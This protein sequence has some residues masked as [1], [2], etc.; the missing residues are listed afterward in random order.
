MADYLIYGEDFEREGRPL[1]DKEQA[2]E[3]KIMDQREKRWKRAKV[4]LYAKPTE[5]ASPCG[6]LGPLGTP[7][8]ED[9]Y[10]VK[11]L[12]EMPLIEDE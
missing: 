8:D 3:I 11:V 10:F 4:L 6:L 5:G 1:L 7:Y 9:K 12:E 2:V